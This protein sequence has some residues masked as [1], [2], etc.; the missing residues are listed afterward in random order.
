MEKKNMYKG[1]LILITILI[2]L[3]LI[4]PWN[5]KI[6]LGLD[7]K[8][9]AHL[10]L[11]V[12]TLSTIKNEVYTMK[13]R[14]KSH[15]QTK[16]VEIKSF[17]VKD[18][19][20]LIME[21]MQESDLEKVSKLLTDDFPNF[22]FTT[23]YE[24]N[25]LTL[26]L[27]LIQDI[28][29]KIRDSSVNQAIETIRGR[30]DELGVS[31]INIQREGMTGNRILI[32]LPGVA[33][34]N[35]AKRIIG[36][37][38]FLEWRAVVSSGKTKDDI[39]KAFP[40]GK[41]PEDCEILPQM[42]KKGGQNVTK[43][44]DLL[45]KESVISGADLQDARS[46]YDN[47]NLPAVSFTLHPDAGKRFYDF[48]GANVGKQLAIVLDKV[49]LSAPVVRDKIR[50]T[51]IISGSF[52]QEEAEELALVLRS[53]ALPASIKFLEERTVG[54]SLGQDSINQGL[55]AG[56]V[57][58]TLVVIFMLIYYGK[59]GVIAVF[60]LILNILYIFAGLSALDAVLTLPGIAG[61]VLTIGMA[62]DA[63]I[64]IFERIH[65]EKSKKITIKHGSFEK[66]KPFK[67]A[68]SD[69]FS[70]ATITIWDSNLTTLIAG[71]ILFVFGTGSIKG[72]AITLSIGIAFNIFTSVFV[73]HLLFD[74]LLDF[75]T[76]KAQK[77]PEILQTQTP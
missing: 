20:D 72:F 67:S 4:I 25:P 76:P 55:K 66:I 59:M 2:S 40:D 34:V 13:E 36:R 63:N 33:D 24:G 77:Q 6:K 11:E 61:I 43:E 23:D 22:H 60:G 58:S 30:I 74:L 39:I 12:D 26:Q 54:P 70:R 7:L 16:K 65:E 73:C 18:N 46:S 56:L 44:Y 75:L 41:I 32:Q 42:E 38:A 69:G 37:T 51:G 8:G 48:T 68:I 19:N 35:K 31:E 71:I 47:S 1:L 50:E 14:L 27:T 29:N 52:T 49:V 62:V 21:I 28:T 3:Y 9:G 64:L 57:G 15:F 45:K 5:Q 53:G 10:I 17:V